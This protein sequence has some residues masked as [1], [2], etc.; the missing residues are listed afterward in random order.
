MM[1]QR[2]FFQPPCVAVWLVNLFTPAKE[3]ESILG[4]LLEEFSQLDIEIGTLPL[5]GG[6]I[7]DKL[8]KLFRI[9]S[10]PACVLRRVDR[11]CRHGRVSPAEAYLWLA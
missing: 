10:E 5:P 11:G 6:G 8:S 3:A 4:D 9:S 1:P 2:Y 7:G